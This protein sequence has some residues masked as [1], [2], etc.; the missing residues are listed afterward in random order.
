MT[1]ETE[2]EEMV[3]ISETDTMAKALIEKYLYS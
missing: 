1:T 2:T 3:H